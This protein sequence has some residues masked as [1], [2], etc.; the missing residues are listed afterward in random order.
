MVRV[1]DVPRR[2]VDDGGV[3]PEV[4]GQSAATQEPHVCAYVFNAFCDLSEL[5]YAI[6][7]WNEKQRSNLGEGLDVETR[8][9]FYQELEEWS[10]SLSPLI[11]AD[12]N[13]TLATYFLR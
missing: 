1:P 11:R 10:R 9:S 7:D 2:F 6:M 5:L 13:F 3:D 12:S 4:I 8:I